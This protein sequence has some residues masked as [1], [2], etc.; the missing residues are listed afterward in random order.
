MPNWTFDLSSAPNERQQLDS[1]LR[2][3]LAMDNLGRGEE[4]YGSVAITYS[5]DDAKRASLIGVLEGRGVV[6]SWTRK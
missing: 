1:E 5:N 2:N 4:I 3:I 6:F